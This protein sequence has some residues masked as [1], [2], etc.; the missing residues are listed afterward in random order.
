[1]SGSCESLI[2]IDSGY[3]P[4][5]FKALPVRCPPVVNIRTPSE[6]FTLSETLT[7]NEMQ[8]SFNPGGFAYL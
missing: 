7:F 3:G 5:T 2:Q 8:I 6:D 4:G 1:V